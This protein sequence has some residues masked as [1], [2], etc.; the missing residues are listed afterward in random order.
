[1][2]IKCEESRIKNDNSFDFG[3]VH[4]FFENFIDRINVLLVEEGYDIVRLEAIRLIKLVIDLGNLNVHKVIPYV[5]A[6][7][8]DC[9]NEIR[10]IAVDIIQK[11]FS[12]SKDK[13]L[14]AFGEGLKQA[15]IFQKKKYV[16]SK[17]INGFVKII[18]PETKKYKTSNKNIFELLFYK[19]NKKNYKTQK[20]ILEKYIMCLKD[21][22]NIEEMFDSSYTSN[23]DLTK[24]LENFEFYEFVA[25]LIGDFK[26]QS[27]DE[28][29]AIFDKLYIEYENVICIFKA[30]FKQYKEETIVKK[31]DLKLVYNYL[32]A[33]LYLFLFRYLFL[34]YHIFNESQI[35]DIFKLGWNQFL[36]KNDIFDTKNVKLPKKL[37]SKLTKFKFIEFY[38]NFEILNIQ[39]FENQS[40]SIS[41]F[42][43]DNK[44]NIIS[45][46]SKL[47]SFSNFDIFKLI[48][49]FNG[50]K[51]SYSDLTFKIIFSDSFA[52]DSEIKGKRK[53]LFN[54][55]IKI[56]NRFS[57]KSF[58]KGKIDKVEDEKEKSDEEEEEKSKK[59]N[60]KKNYKID[61]KDYQKAKKKNKRR[62]TCI[63]IEN[64][65]EENDFTE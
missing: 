12:F 15:F 7:L 52:K 13:T 44:A 57:M 2:S 43:K 14:N 23:S 38:S 5:F 21:I 58:S 26:F 32:K 54:P 25:K 4:L 47:K 22:S 20:K 31:M 60:V 61:E 65:K 18:D 45:C 16:S 48:E 9:V 40:K 41:R 29:Y 50:K 3:I 42:S 34:K 19:N 1:M 37:E 6:S 11:G 17:L 10:C 24:C 59:R 55:D 53:T 46:L 36:S 56:K 27:P 51:K 28:I 62:K 35:N 39:L 49:L 30:K 33:G 63:V 64:E 8:F